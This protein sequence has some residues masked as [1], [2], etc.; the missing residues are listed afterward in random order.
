V[1]EIAMV[2]IAVVEEEEGAEEEVFSEGEDGIV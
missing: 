2:E 1:V